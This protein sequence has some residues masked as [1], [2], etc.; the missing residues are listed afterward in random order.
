MCAAPY[1]WI[2]SSDDQSR[3]LEDSAVVAYYE[4]EMR[5]VC[6]KA[7]EVSAGSPEFVSVGPIRSPTAA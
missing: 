3:H 7:G 6:G 1:Q 5:R 2:E 4:A